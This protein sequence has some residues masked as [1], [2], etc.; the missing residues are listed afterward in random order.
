MIRNSNRS[1][2][3]EEPNEPERARR[4]D[5][6]RSG[7]SDDPAPNTSVKSE[8]RMHIREIRGRLEVVEDTD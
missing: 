5:S 2:Q 3:A 8:R 7:T 1:G 4:K 6:T